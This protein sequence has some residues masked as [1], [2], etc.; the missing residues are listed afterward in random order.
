MSCD[1]AEPRGLVTVQGRPQ[2]ADAGCETFTAFLEL[3][4]LNYCPNVL[5]ASGALKFHRPDYRGRKNH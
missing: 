3:D 5:G 4:S 2:Y 1:A